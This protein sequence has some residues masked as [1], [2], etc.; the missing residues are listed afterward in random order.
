MKKPISILS[1]ALFFVLLPV[2]MR[3]QNQALVIEGGTLIDG[4]G[5]APVRDAVIVI[6]GSRIKAVGTKGKVSLPAQAKVIQ[7]GGKTILPGLVDSHIHSLDWFPP[8]FLHWGV[9][10]VFDTANPTEWSVAQRDAVNK[11]R[12]KGPRMFVTGI[13]IDGPPSG[14]DDP[15]DRRES[16]R[17]RVRTTEEARV[18]VRNVVK[19]GVDGIKVHEALSAE[20]L[21]AVIDEA[22]KSGLEVVGHEHDVREAVDAGMK[23]I[24][25]PYSIIHATITDPAKL[26]AYEAGTLRFAEADMDTGLFD[27]IIESMVKNRVFFNP[28]LTRTGFVLMSERQEWTQLAVKLLEDPSY[29]FINAG[30]REFWLRGARAGGPPP[31]PNTLQR[32]MEGLRKVQEFTR[33]YAKAGGRIINGPDSGPSSPATNMAGLAMHIEMQA[34]VDAGLTP[35]QAIQSSTKWPAEQMKK[36]KDFGTIEPGKF[37][38]VILID[39]DP[40]ANIQA[41]REIRTV[42]M[43]GKVIDTTLDPK[44]RNPLPRPFFG[45]I[46][47]E[48]PAP[49]IYE[50]APHIAREGDAKV[51]LAIG[52]IKFTPQSVVRFDTT[53]LPTK[54]VSDSKLTATVNGALLKKVGTYAVTVV[55]PGSVGGTSRSAYFVVNFKD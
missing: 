40:L 5:G 24:E 3:G 32:R 36:D 25:H 41:T 15:S 48:D 53:D 47:S 9:T 49:D 16:Y 4:N 35:M 34:L 43:N 38:D 19:Q 12:I 51:D 23:F 18:A 33:K 10:T 26:K 50:I 54:F 14:S 30:R 29:A 8:L 45:D 52:G 1:I 55:N 13:I 21:K 6:E 22:H 46:P 20:L 7:A 2:A 39:G 28:T 37:A 42:I 11:G 17:V 44:F 31:D 27:P